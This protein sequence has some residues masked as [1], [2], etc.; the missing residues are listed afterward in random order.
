MINI[1]DKSTCC[2][3]TACANICPHNAIT[4][5]PDSLGFKYPIVDLA[6]CTNCGLCEKVCAFNENYD[7]SLNLERPLIFGVKHK[8]IQQIE[9]SQSGAAFIPFSDY[10]LENGGIVYG[11]GYS[12][13]FTVIHKRATTKKERDEFRGSKYVQSDLTDIFK[14]IKTD[15]KN[16]KLVCF[17]GT[18]CQTAGLNS[19]VGKK[20]RNNLFLI[21]IVCHG[22]PAPN[23]WRDNLKY[24][25]NKYHSEITKVNFRDKSKGWKSS[26]ESYQFSTKKQYSKVYTHIFLSNIALRKSC[27]SCHFTNK[28][29]PSDISIADFWGVEKYNP[30]FA[31]DNKGCSVIFINTNNGLNLFKKIKSQFD[32]LTDIKNYSQPNLEHPSKSHIK[33]EQF[34]KD[35][36]SYGFQYCCKKYNFTTFRFKII[37]TM[38]RTQN[39]ILSLAKKITH[40]KNKYNKA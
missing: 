39:V 35:Y 14:Q 1:T 28:T 23:L 10:I 15:L 21:D 40:L 34:I 8:D 29:R 11:A 31:N 22:V 12:D 5:R 17:S 3:C 13:D 18:P 30:D 9:Q 36:E 19:F 37:C 32:I 6:K 4:M 38:M 25:S 24:I 16:G 27:Y 2:G 33:R 7:K 26:I 20:L